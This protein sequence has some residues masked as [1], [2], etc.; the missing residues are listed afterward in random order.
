MGDPE[1]YIDEH[2]FL[3]TQG[4]LINSIIFEGILTNK[5]IILT[6]KTANLLPRMEIPLIRLR[7]IE[8]AE[9]ASGDE[10]IILTIQTGAS[11]T[12]EIMLT[13]SCQTPGTQMNERDAWL[14]I[15]KWV[16]ILKKN[17]S[18]SSAEQEIHTMIPDHEQVS[19]GIEEVRPPLPDYVPVVIESTVKKE[20]AVPPP[21]AWIKELS[22]PSPQRTISKIYDVSPSD[23]RTFSPPEKE[24]HNLIFGLIFLILLIIC[25]MILSITSTFYVQ[26]SLNTPAQISSSM[27]PAISLNQNPPDTESII[28]LIPTD[29]PPDNSAAAVPDASF[30]VTDAGGA[31]VSEIISPY[32]TIESKP[33]PGMK[34]HVFLQPS[35]AQKSEEGYVTIYSLTN[36]NVSQ[37]LPLVS[38]TLY[39]PPLMIN[40]NFT[41]INQIRIKHLEYK[42]VETNFKEDLEIHRSFEDSWFR[43]I[44]RDKDTGDII[45]EEG[46]GGNYSLQTPKQLVVRENGNFSFEFTGGY[47]V[48]DLTM[49]V[50]QEGNLPASERINEQSTTIPV[51]SMI[52]VVPTTQTTQKPPQTTTTTVPTPTRTP[53]TPT[54]IPFTTTVPLP[55]QAG[56]KN[57]V[58]TAAADGRFTTFVATLKAA[59]LTET[60]S[61]DDP[62]TVFAPTDDAFNELS[63]GSMDI[64]LKDPQG[65]LLQILLYHGINGKV[66]AADL[67]KLISVETLQG[68]TLPINVSNGIIMVDGATVIVTDIE[69]TNGV[70][71]VVDSVMLP[72]A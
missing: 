10:I 1:L 45:S 72:P 7:N 28:N 23:S 62:F 43:I 5:R 58:D 37:F 64:L 18:S 70:I 31:P 57:I 17:A 22:P 46:I 63:A 65:D 15:L 40:Y 26:D 48:L 8:A 32:V 50:K 4:I 27:P 36:Q 33:S 35:I 9:D 24:F 2:I 69:C 34:R 49:K 19:R 56:M 29:I 41:P 67:K 66:T 68:G 71:H 20:V 11:E 39:N 21:P 52:T 44:V 53:P 6:H 12:R 3:R 13:F 30:V 47:G 25:P 14:R 16:G 51:P 61:G 38:F 42:M 59:N 55:S 60:F 54:P